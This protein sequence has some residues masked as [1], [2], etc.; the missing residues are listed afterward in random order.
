MYNYPHL[1]SNVQCMP[2][3]GV[4]ISQLL[5]FARACD[6]YSDLLPRHRHLVQKLLDQGFQY[7]LLCRKFKQFYWSHHS[8]VR[9]FSH[10]V[11]QHLREGFHSQV[12]WWRIRILL[13]GTALTGTDWLPI[14]PF[15]GVLLAFPLF[16]KIFIYFLKFL[17]IFFCFYFF[18]LLF[19]DL[20]FN[21]FLF[22]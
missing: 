2:M 9:R 11:T 12:Q 5:H 17:S 15:T 10:S 14:S 22:L 7:G 20:F 16:L 3:Y 1:D 13:V 21:F 4:Y 8:L 19:I 18:I 6:R